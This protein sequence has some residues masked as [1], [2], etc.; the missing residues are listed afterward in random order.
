M[1]LNKEFPDIKNNFSS[2]EKSVPGSATPSDMRARRPPS[3][4]APQL[5][6]AQRCGRDGPPLPPALLSCSSASHRPSLRCGTAGGGKSHVE[7]LLV[8]KFGGIIRAGEVGKSFRNQR[9]Y[10]GVFQCVQC[11]GHVGNSSE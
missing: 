10:P 6:V 8:N 7:N 4:P 5:G 1:I 2:I 9:T 11:Y 3:P